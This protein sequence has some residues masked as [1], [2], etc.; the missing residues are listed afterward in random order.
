MDYNN[1]L[2]QKKCDFL[3]IEFE[4]QQTLAV[5]I[6][7]GYHNKVTKFTFNFAKFMLNEF[8]C[9]LNYHALA[10]FLLLQLHPLMVFKSYLST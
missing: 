3:S 1:A 9:T 8:D 7:K 5:S 10:Y 6:I 2:Y 4:T